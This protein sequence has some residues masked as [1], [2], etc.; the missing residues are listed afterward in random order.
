[1]AAWGAAGGIVL[2]F[3]CF[4]TPLGMGSNLPGTL[5][6]GVIGSVLGFAL[7][8]IERILYR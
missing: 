3:T 4:S 8:N 5:L 1:M 2:H 7:G 6:F